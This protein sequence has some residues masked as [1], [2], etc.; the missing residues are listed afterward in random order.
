MEKKDRR[1]NKCA[2]PNCRGVVYRHNNNVECTGC[3]M[4]VSCKRAD[5]KNLQTM[6]ELK[7]LWQ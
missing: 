6:S 2:T 3:D 4:S 7:K 5:D 1:L